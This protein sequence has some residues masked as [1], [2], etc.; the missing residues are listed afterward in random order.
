V[1]FYKAAAGFLQT[2]APR[3]FHGRSAGRHLG[4]RP[5]SRIA[6]PSHLGG[7]TYLMPSWSADGQ[8]I[9]YVRQ[10]GVTAVTGT[11]LR[12]RLANGGGQ[13][14]I[15]MEGENSAS[16]HTLTEPQCRP[17]DATSCTSS[18]A[19]R[20]LPV[21]G[22]C[23]LRATRT[24]RRRSAADSASPNH[25]SPS[26]S[27]RPLVGLQFNRVGTGGSLCNSLPSGA[28]MAVSQT[29]GTFQPGEGQQGDLLFGVDSYL[30]G[31]TVNTK[32]DEFELDPCVRCSR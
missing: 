4:V 22:R 20:P 10:S 30:H 5:G 24:I 27:R 9:I 32:S 16:A 6:Y 12:S 29:G 7:A 2:Q 8:R 25:S 19:A 14:E 28:A 18:R 3:G 23:L 15:L 1:A 17:T 31:A 11:S 13:E 26:I 21:F